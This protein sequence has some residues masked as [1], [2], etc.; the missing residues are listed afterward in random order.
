MY[1]LFIFFM[2]TDPKTT[3]KSKKW[4]C[5]VVAIVAIVEMVLR[6]DQVVY[7]PFYALF[8][9]GPAALLIE[10]WFELRSRKSVSMASATA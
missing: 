3:V 9:V 10:Y 2:I 1:Q 4:Q 6:L 7:A 5:I 8:L